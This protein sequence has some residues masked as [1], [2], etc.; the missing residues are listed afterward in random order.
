[1]RKGCLPVMARDC[2]KFEAT[3]AFAREKSFAQ[4]F[5]HA[6]GFAASAPYLE[7]G[8]PNGG[9]IGVA[10]STGGAMQ[11]YEAPQNVRGLELAR[12]FF[13]EAAQPIIARRWPGLPYSAAL[14]GSGSEVL[15][16]D[17]AVSTDH[18]WGPRFMLFLAPV[19]HHRL[20]KELHET[21]ATELPYRFMGYS[22][23]FS[24]PKTGDGDQ[25]TQLLQDISAGKI[26]HRIEILTLYSYLQDTLGLSA[27]QELTAADWLS[28]PQQKLLSF[29][30]GEVFHDALGL[31]LLR[32]RFRYYP[33]DIWLYL[34]ACGWSR[35]GQ[36]EHLA[37]R[38]GARGDE[39]GSAVIAGR[40]ARS[41]MLLCFLYEKRYAP[42][43]KW[44]GTAFAE[45]SCAAELAP[46][47]RAA[48]RG[49][50]WRER[51]RDL[52]RAYE[53]LNRLHNGARLTAPIQPATQDFHGRGFLVSNA[54]RYIEPLVAKI[55]DPEVKAI[56]AGSLIG[57]IDLFSDNTDLRE[58]ARLRGKIANLC[59]F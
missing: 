20:A 55:V 24:A 35:I 49:A 3:F 6:N 36:D 17:D 42:Y 40:L 56:A 52:G 37:P 57:G 50:S 21:L 46:T 16:Y 44:L 4:M 45:L 53:A 8:R 39:L 51:E 7:G 12:A 30:S 11:E 29:T 13:H 59:A 28:L 34:L 23:N 38:A 9:T 19:D 31:G 33:R 15:G 58:A 10:T 26:N 14:I 47:L 25:G 27:D 54:W 43:P 1:M 22:T 48:L 5:D 32:D 18:H 41:I 2:A